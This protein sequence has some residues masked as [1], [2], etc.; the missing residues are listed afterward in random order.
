M[1]SYTLGAPECANATIDLV[2]LRRYFDRY[3]ERLALNE[4][5]LQMAAKPA[6]YDSIHTDFGYREYLNDGADNFESLVGYAS[7]NVRFGKWYEEINAKIVEALITERANRIEGIRGAVRNLTMS[8]SFIRS[9]VDKYLV[10]PL[11]KDAP[12][13]LPRL[14]IQAAPCHKLLLSSPL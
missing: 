11:H 4:Y 1:R 3:Q 9:V 14:P 8:T 2:N 10:Q 5:D 13:L 7:W 6:Y 12:P